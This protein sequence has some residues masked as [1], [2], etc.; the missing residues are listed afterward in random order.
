[1]QIYTYFLI[2]ALAQVYNPCDFEGRQWHKHR[3]T[4]PVLAFKMRYGHK[5]AEKAGKMKDKSSV[6][7]TMIT[8]A[9]LLLNVL[10]QYLDSLTSTLKSINKHKLNRQNLLEQKL[11]DSTGSLPS[12][13]T[14]LNPHCLF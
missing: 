13:F 6:A 5:C 11:A 7:M 12:G 10:K 2:T 8:N 4:L 1:M 9:N 14:K 3:L